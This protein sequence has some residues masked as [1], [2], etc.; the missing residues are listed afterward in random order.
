MTDE[1][2]RLR[3]A[4]DATRPQP[5]PGVRRESASL[6]LVRVGARRRCHDVIE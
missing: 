5:D 1:M 3:E 2:N 6:L 4:L